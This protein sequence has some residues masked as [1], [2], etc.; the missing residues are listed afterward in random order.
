MTYIFIIY[1]IDEY[2]GLIVTERATG[3]TPDVETQAEAL[4]RALGM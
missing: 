1:K 2:L 4:G 3:T